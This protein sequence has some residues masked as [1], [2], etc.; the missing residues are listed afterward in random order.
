MKHAGERTLTE[1]F[2]QG[3]GHAVT[4]NHSG[5]FK[6]QSVVIP[7]GKLNIWLELV[8]GKKDGHNCQV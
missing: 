8:A 2:F 5:D 4:E 1:N 3:E 7:L 6:E